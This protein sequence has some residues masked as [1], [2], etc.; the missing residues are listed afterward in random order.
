MPNVS[1]S[2][3]KV[4]IGEITKRGNSLLKETIIEC[5]W[6]A[7]KNDPALL[8]KYNQLCQIMEPN[9][10]IIRI[11]KKLLNR[12]RFVLKNQKPYIK[13]TV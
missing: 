12:I 3:D 6:I 11:A 4:W 9:K 1:G 13:R 10:A 2:G 5:S 7:I 8:M